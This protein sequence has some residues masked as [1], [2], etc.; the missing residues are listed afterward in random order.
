MDGRSRQQMIGGDQ[1]LVNHREEACLTTLL[2]LHAA[3]PVNGN[4]DAVHL[5]YP[6]RNVNMVL[7]QSLLTR[8]AEIPKPT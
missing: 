4:D 6:P 1:L 2:S 7:Q 5:F 8:I 3:L